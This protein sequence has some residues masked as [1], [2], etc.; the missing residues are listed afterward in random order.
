[1]QELEELQIWPLDL[2]DHLLFIGC[3][4]DARSAAVI[5]DM[6]FRA[7]VLLDTTDDKDFAWYVSELF[8]ACNPDS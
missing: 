5:K 8:G 6:Q 3:R 4:E 2:Y 7:V 1:M